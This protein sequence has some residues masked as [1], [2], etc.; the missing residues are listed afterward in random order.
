[1]KFEKLYWQVLAFV[2]IIFVLSIIMGGIRYHESNRPPITDEVEAV[3]N[4]LGCSYI[5][6]SYRNPKNFY[7]DCGDD[8]IRIIELD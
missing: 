6:Q 4:D 8:Q 7:I 5:E 3:A 1:M 2:C